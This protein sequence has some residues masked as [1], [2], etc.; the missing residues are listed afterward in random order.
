RDFHVTG[1]QTCALPIS[2]FLFGSLAIGLWI[3]PRVVKRLARLEIENL[4]L[5]FGLGF[6]FLL[7]WLAN[8]FGLATVVGAFAAGLV[9]E[10]FFEIGRA[11]CRVRGD[12]SEV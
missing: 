11:S 12:V 5:L 9:L 1:V 7:S 10:G 6:A 2:V 3:T 8:A 4:K